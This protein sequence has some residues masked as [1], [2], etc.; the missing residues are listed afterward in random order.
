[1]K[2]SGGSAGLAGV[3]DRVTLA[4]AI[5]KFGVASRAQAR[6]MIASGSVSVNGKTLRNPDHWV[7]PKEDRITVEGRRVRT[8]ARIYLMMHKPR[9]LISTRSDEKG[10]RTVY[11]LLPAGIPWVFPV[12]RLDR[13]TSG[14]LLFTNDTRFGESATNPIEKVSKR[15]RVL[16]NRAISPA[17]RRVIESGM[18]LD[19]ST[20][21]RPAAVGVEQENP[22]GCD[23]TLHEGKNRQIRRM[24]ETLGYEVLS[25]SRIAIGGISL[26]DLREGLTRPLTAAEVTSIVGQG[27]RRE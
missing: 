9:G 10:R 26:G 19:D 13:E 24:L 27:R 12:G 15:Y 20:R 25:L 6:M 23:I 14:L 18:V 21:L 5:S 2:R 7:N 22:L 17:D 11:D 3:K 1:V 4:R 16:L 8:P